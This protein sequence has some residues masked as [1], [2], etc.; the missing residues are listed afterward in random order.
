MPT[1]PATS[2]PP[3]APEAH[4]RL[5]AA[6]ASPEPADPMGHFQ[7]SQFAW[8]LLQGLHSGASSLVRVPA[9]VCVR[10]GM[11]WG[12]CVSLLR[13]VTLCPVSSQ[14]LDGHAP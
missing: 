9:F 11:H 6:T 14:C 12:E 5:G 2:A 4:L 1:G 7:S 13:G 8:S 10:L 3:P